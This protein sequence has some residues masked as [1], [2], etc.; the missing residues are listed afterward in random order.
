MILPILKNS[1]AILSHARHRRPLNSSTE[2]RLTRLC[3]QRCRQCQVYER[4]TEPAS[5]DLGM[6]RHIARELQHYGAYIGFISGGEAT[7][8]PDLPEILLEAKKTFPVA[9]TL[10]TGLYNQSERIRTIGRFCLD[11]DINIQTSLDGF[12]ETGDL[13][14]GARDFS[15]TV[16]Q[17]MEMIAAMR[18]SSRALLYCN[19]VLSSFNLGQVPE[20][21]ATAKR[22]GWKATIGLYHHLTETTRDDDDLLVQPGDRLLRLTAFLDNNPDI[23]NLNAWIRGIEPFVRARETTPCPFV[24]SRFLSSRTTIMENGDLHLCWGGPIGNLFNS[25]MKEILSSPAYRERLEAYSQCSGCWTTCYTQR[26]LLIH[27][28]SL[29][30]AINNARKIIR[31]QRRRA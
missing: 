27:P 28:R 25:S 24:G 7:L 8:V 31:M 3:T 22:I 13:L 23:L 9:T 4:T 29:G 11:H 16:L 19:I 5:M 14:R 30:E 12:G 26:Y 2:V 15:R 10:V 18:G 21:I 6:F 1:R 20:L 17:H